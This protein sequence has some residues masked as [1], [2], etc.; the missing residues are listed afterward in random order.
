MLFGTLESSP[1]F[2]RILNPW[3]SSRPS[4]A[5]GLEKAWKMND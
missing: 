5:A 1:C 4:D 2:S 3:F